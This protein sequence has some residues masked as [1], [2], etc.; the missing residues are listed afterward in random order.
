MTKNSISIGE[1]VSRLGRA[2]AICGG[3]LR[4]MSLATVVA[5]GTLANAGYATENETDAPTSAIV[6]TTVTEVLPIL[7][8]ADVVFLGE[9]HDNP[10]HHAVQAELVAQLRPS[11]V[12]WEMITQA[13]AASLSPELLHHGPALAEALDWAESGWPD[14]TLYQPIFAA[15]AKAVQFGALVPRAET[16]RAM[17]IGVATFFGPDAGLYG[18]TEPL[19]KADQTMREADQLA[20]HCNAVPAE[21]LPVLVDLQRLR[22]AELARGVTMALE[23]SMVAGSEQTAGPVIVITGNGHARRD[24]GAPVALQLARPD[25]AI[26]SLGQSEDGQIAGAFDV[27]LDAPALFRPDPCLAFQ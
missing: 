8:N 23:Q 27:E 17:E 15:G 3:G 13:Q 25:L 12:V 14:F 16:R 18:L 24:R 5:M 19:P 1:G 9:V 26:A 11:A 22:D 7:A 2:F 10:A 21:I 20:N 6:V 4:R